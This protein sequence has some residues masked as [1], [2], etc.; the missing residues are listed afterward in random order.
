MMNYLLTIHGYVVRD[1]ELTTP[2][3]CPKIRHDHT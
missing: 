1:K 3:L 2:N